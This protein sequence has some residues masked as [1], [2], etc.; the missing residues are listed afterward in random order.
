MSYEVAIAAFFED[1][2]ARVKAKEV[3]LGQ[4]N[5]CRM[6][7]LGFS[8]SRTAFLISSLPRM[9]GWRNG[10]DC[11]TCGGSPNSIHLSSLSAL[12]LA[13]LTLAVEGTPKTLNGLMR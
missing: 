6:R 12:R 10:S 1:L 3:E 2:L 11:V 5:S 4:N 8:I 13:S 9:I 7:W